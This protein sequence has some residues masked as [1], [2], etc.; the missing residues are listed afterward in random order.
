MIAC[1]RSCDCCRKLGTYDPEAKNC[2]WVYLNDMLL[3]RSCFT[4]EFLMRG[5]IEEYA[6][7]GAF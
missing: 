5:P 7:Y 4:A 3:C 6:H 2:N 1:Y